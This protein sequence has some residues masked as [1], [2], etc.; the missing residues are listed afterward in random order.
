[1]PPATLGAPQLA[2][3]LGLRPPCPAGL[4][5]REP[6][7]TPPSSTGNMDRHHYETF[8]KFGD[9]GFLIHLDNARGFGRHSHDEISILSPLSQCCRIKRKT[10]SH[11]QL[12]ARADY[13]LSDVMRESLLQ[14]QLSPVLTEPHLLALDR[15]LQTV[16]RTVRGCIEAH[17][18][19]SV[20]ANGPTGQSAPDSGPS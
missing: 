16:L 19:H 12:L 7:P 2:A 10:L 8:S 9:D 1:M 4:T 3:G 13:R 11:L 20:V 14:D 5:G 6:A 15:R 18:E 17:G